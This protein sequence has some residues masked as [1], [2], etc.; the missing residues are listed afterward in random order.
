M[1]KAQDGYRIAPHRGRL[2]VVW[3][4]DGQRQRRSL[5]TDDPATA[6]ARLGEFIALKERQER[7]N[8]M[9]VGAILDAYQ[10][11]KSSR[12]ASPDAIKYAVQALK[13]H[14]GDL[15]PEHI[16]RTQCEGYAKL[17]SKAGRKP[18]TARNE[19]GVL[20]SALLWAQKDKQWI[21]AP[22]VWKPHSQPPRERH[23]S[24]EEA[25]KI[26]AAAEATHLKLFIQLGLHTAGRMRALLELT[27]DRVDFAAGLIYLAASQRQHRAKGRATVPMTDT[28]RAALEEAKRGALTNYVIEYAGGPVKNI[29]KGFRGVVERAR[30]PWCSPHTLRHTAAV[31]MVQAGVPIKDVADFLGHQDSRTTERH[32]VHFQPQRLRAAARALEG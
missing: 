1:R 22:H 11:E 15:F 25:A 16:N 5:G 6:R 18:G 7:P 30:I 4:E 14:F 17:R 13:P 26:I 29:G 8:R 3:Y 10:R 31:W 32:Y 21:T 20:R 12:V 27:W 24:R 19:L 28:L 2:A 23:L 9:T